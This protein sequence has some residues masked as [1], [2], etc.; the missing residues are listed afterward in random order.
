MLLQLVLLP[1]LG[2]KEAMRTLGYPIALKLED[3]LGFEHSSVDR[4]TNTGLYD[5]DSFL[6]N[7]QVKITNCIPPSMSHSSEKVSLHPQQWY[8][9]AVQK[10]WNQLS[11][12]QPREE[13]NKPNVQ[14]D[15]IHSINLRLKT[16]QLADQNTTY[17]KEEAGKN[18]RTK[19]HYNF[20]S[21][22]IEVMINLR[23]KQVYK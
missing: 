4:Q 11:I 2:H 14:T 12:Q 5:I 20:E 13:L 17:I 7:L 8:K 3:Q 6:F 1:L 9:Y 15:K 10:R 19:Y 16:K 21:N 23:A 22:E 18:K